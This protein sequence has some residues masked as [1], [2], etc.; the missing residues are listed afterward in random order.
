VQ[1]RQVGPHDR[2]YLVYDITHIEETEEGLFIFVVALAVLVVLAVWVFGRRVVDRALYQ[3]DQLV[4]QISALVPEKGEQRL[5][6]IDADPEL[7]VI[8]DALNH[9][10]GQVD[11][12]VERERLFA[13]AASH[14]L[15]TPLSVIQG[16]AA[17]IA[18][19]PEVPARVRKRLTRAVR[20]ICEDLDALLV[21]SQQ[22]GQLSVETLRLDRHLPQIV[23]I[24][25]ADARPAAPIRWI[26]PQPV[27]LTA[28]AGAVNVVFGNLLRNALRAAQGSEIVIEVTP[29]QVSVSNIGP[30]IPEHELP[31][32]FEPHFRGRD[33]GSGMGLYIAMT[34]GRRFGWSLAL[35]NRPEG[36]VRAE[37]R[38]AAEPV[39]YQH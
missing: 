29:G 16:S 37:W 21:L 13:A 6:L 20:E 5:R 28:P 24:Y 26:A 17:L 19:N 2:S 32:V 33:G 36:G 18:E 39:P 9:Y 34:L 15:R 7:G 12:F 1:V 30:A 35:V 27:V 38:F 31:H 25:L 14:E 4:A 10:M 23:E 11:A 3:L 22:H 8:V